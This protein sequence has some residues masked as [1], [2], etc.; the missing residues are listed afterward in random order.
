VKLPV[1]DLSRWHVPKLS[2]SVMFLPDK[3]FPVVRVVASI[4]DRDTGEPG[5]VVNCTSLSWTQANNVR[6][7]KAMI[8]AAIA[9]VILHELDECLYIDGE[10]LCA[11]PHPELSRGADSIADEQSPDESK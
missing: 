8:H 6:I 11:D 2:A 10:R 5:Y 4:H 9:E 7:L 3:E 1:V